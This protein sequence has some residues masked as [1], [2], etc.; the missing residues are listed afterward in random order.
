MHNDV[1]VSV[2]HIHLPG[3]ESFS[4]LTLNLSLTPGRTRRIY[5]IT[6]ILE[7]IVV[8]YVTNTSVTR[9]LEASSVHTL[10]VDLTVKQEASCVQQLNFGNEQ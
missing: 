4:A 8:Q 2:F 3:G 9:K 1:R 10:S 7:P 5:D 6:T